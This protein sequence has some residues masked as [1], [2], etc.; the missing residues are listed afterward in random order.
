[1]NRSLSMMPNYRGNMPS[2]MVDGRTVQTMP[3][4][5]MT[6]HH[7]A[8]A[9][10]DMIYGKQGGSQTVV[11]GSGSVPLR[12]VT[13][14]STN[15]PR[16]SPQPLIP[17]S[18][19]NAIAAAAAN[20]VLSRT[21]GGTT[22]GGRPAITP[23]SIPERSTGAPLA[24]AA[25]QAS[26][27][28]TTTSTASSADWQSSLPPPPMLPQA[29]TAAGTLPSLPSLPSLPTLGGAAGT[30]AGQS[31]ASLIIAAGSH[32]YRQP[33]ATTT[34]TT[35]T[36]ATSTQAPQIR[37]RPTTAT[38]ATTAAQRKAGAMPSASSV[39]P[40]TTTT[41]DGKTGLASTSM[42]DTVARAAIAA[43]QAAAADGKASTT[44]AAQEAVNQAMAAAAASG[45]TPSGV[46]T[47]LPVSSSV[48]PPIVNGK[49][50]RQ[51]AS[52]PK[53]GHAPDVSE[54]PDAIV[55]VPI[56]RI[57]FTTEAQYIERDSPHPHKQVHMFIEVYTTRGQYELNT[58][59]GSQFVAG[60]ETIQVSQVG[61]RGGRQGG[62]LWFS[63]P[64]VAEAAHIAP[65]ARSSAFKT[66]Y[67]R[68]WPRRFP[69]KLDT[70]PAPDPDIIAQ[71]Q[72][73]SYFQ[74][75]SF[76]PL[77]FIIAAFMEAPSGSSRQQKSLLRGEAVCAIT[78]QRFVFDFLTLFSFSSLSVHFFG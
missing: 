47:G 59:T 4:P 12:T 70:C 14:S 22:A 25:P 68:P 78:Q 56:D 10:H 74:A 60:S 7:D 29:G 39:T 77:V 9:Q 51:P 44:A 67:L 62:I 63:G 8:A 18:T 21:A 45:S 20:A 64:R 5:P 49:G 65:A 43:A 24:V 23:G 52:K 33:S 58:G 27:T 69:P 26:S 28:G 46:P 55:K 38:T 42:V 31:P 66:Q 35:A 30:S 17:P 3:M 15:V 16:S 50:G 41:M 40:S 61:P 36:G 57:P 54:G 75:A 76:Q 6:G 73:V 48:L 1:M 32:P 72:Q 53:H 13:A 11:P 19:S 2:R 34:T 71:L 37:G